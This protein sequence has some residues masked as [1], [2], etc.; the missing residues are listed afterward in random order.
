[1]KAKNKSAYHWVIL[2]CC[3]LTLMFAYST[4]VSLAQL[5]S[6]EILKE[7]GFS[8]GAYFLT[9]MITSILCIIASPI[10]GKML[11]GK[12]MRIVFIVCCIGTMG[13]YMG[14]G[15]CH[16]LWQF[17]I[18]AALVG[19]FAMGA[20]TIPVTLIITN[21]F[22]K[23]RGLMISVALMGISIGGMVLSPILSAII[24]QF[25]WRKAYFILGIVSLIVL[26]P[27]SVFIVRRTP[28]DAGL[29]PYGQGEEV[30]AKE[31]KKSYPTSTW[32]ATLKEA[33]QTP[34]IWILGIAGFFI[35]FS[36]GIIMHQSYYLQGAGFSAG[37]IAAFISLYSAV[38]IVGKLV[39]G[40]IFD[41][42]GPRAGILFG[43]GTFALYL[44][45]FIFIGN[46]TGMMYLAAVLYGFGTC[47]ATVALPIITTQI[48][49]PKNY[50]ELY[51]FLSAF[52]MT[53]NAIGS[54]GIGFVRDLTGSYTIALW[55]LVA[56]TVVAAAFVFLCI[57]SSE[58][59]AKKETV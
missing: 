31:K 57:R 10:I 38:A 13:T 50:S 58:K 14:Y 16:E 9:S 24:G 49:G 12:Y 42:F 53:G 4:G 45:C 2:V 46:S 52:T 1:M 56:L 8:T 19:V 41:R 30:Q 55:V 21:W 37:S 27:I 36:A 39:L 5:F 20:G 15:L 25:G 54:T 23:N 29:L 28:E 40:H 17:Y 3:I 18:V 33:R 32:N 7:T 34:I 6:T 35:Y 48:F 11:R 59:H 43:C 47:T 44:L 26:I 22:E 51:G